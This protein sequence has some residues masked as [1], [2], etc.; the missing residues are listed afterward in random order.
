MGPPTCDDPGVTT[1]TVSPPT[2]PFEAEVAVPGDKSLSHRALL[3]AAM[4]TGESRIHGVGTGADIAA[5][6]RV[7][8]A[9]GAEFDGESVLGPGVAGW[10]TPSAV[11]DCGNSGTTMR[12]M[13]GAL[14]GTHLR[15]TIDGDASLRRRPMG[16]LASALAPL[17]ARITTTGEG[18]PPLRVA[19]TDLHG[20]QIT[21]G[22]ASAQLR[23]AAA[24]A[25][26]Q[27]DGP[28]AIDSPPGYRDHTERWLVCLG[29]GEWGE[30]ERFTVRPGV[31]PPFEV[32]IP[33][34]PS[35]AAFLWAAAALE[36]G[37]RV[38]TPDV[39]L[40][41]GRTGFLDVLRLMGASVEA[42]ETGSVLGDPIGTVTVV[43]RDLQA[44]RIDGGLAARS[45]DELPLAVVLGGKAA[46][47]TVI[48]DASE[49]RVKESDRI[50]S[51]VALVQALGG[52]AEATEDGV[53]VHGTGYRGGIA[54]SAGDHRI[55]MAAAVAAAGA[56]G[57]VQVEGIEAA[58]VSWPGF[59]ETM[60]GLWS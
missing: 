28:T 38:T 48:A 58:D 24:L 18:T 46:G 29:L 39:S 33:G 1:L 54:T 60:E 44:C 41:P 10:S 21:L 59:I 50:A 51:S 34:D 45:I 52:D 15:A 9:L 12:L 2:A 5:T 36:A 20:A 55:A 14:A 57:P 53:I 25:A 56:T 19:G 23:T 40:N 7:L 22:I 16:R 26:L 43:G 13:A 31:V 47:T 17:G 4:A 3:L 37:S 27:A 35:T 11:L 8:D 32:T 6:R 30:G 49:L 42:E